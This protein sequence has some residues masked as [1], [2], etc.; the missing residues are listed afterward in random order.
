MSHG[1]IALMCQL[2]IVDNCI[3]FKFVGV[4][5]DYQQVHKV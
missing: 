5:H 3:L 1:M 2:K 4:I